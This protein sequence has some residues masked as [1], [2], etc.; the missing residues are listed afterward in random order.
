MSWVRSPYWPGN[1]FSQQAVGYSALEMTQAQTFRASIHHQSHTCLVCDVSR[2][3]AGHQNISLTTG[4]EPVR[5]EPN[6]FQVHRLNHSAT[7]A[8][9]YRLCLMF[10]ILKSPRWRL[11]STSSFR[12]VN[13][14][15]KLIRCRQDSN[16]CGHSPMDFES[17]ALTT[18]PRQHIE[19]KWGRL[20]S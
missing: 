1:I 18:R 3:S 17:I 19:R 11:V 2:A 5:A 15:L 8:A 10:N 6:G 4:F 9:K 14:T 16:L 13:T 7:S 20:N 12:K